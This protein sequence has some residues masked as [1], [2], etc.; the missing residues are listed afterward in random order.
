M[1]H[2]TTTVQCRCGHSF[3][4]CVHAPLPP[5]RFDRYTVLC[6][7]NASRLQVSGADLKAVNACPSNAVIVK[8]G[9]Q[10]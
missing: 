10:P 5:T 7:M 4:V 6:P 8:P 2:Y 3:N 9:N 1:R